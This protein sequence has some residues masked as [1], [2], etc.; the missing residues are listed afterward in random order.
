MELD[1]LILFY[2][3][4]QMEM[5]EYEHKKDAITDKRCEIIDVRYWGRGVLLW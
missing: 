3:L 2:H 5:R 4:F 1:N